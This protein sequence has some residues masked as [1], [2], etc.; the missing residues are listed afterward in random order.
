[1]SN[2]TALIP[3]P[4]V[5]YVSPNA[6]G[7]LSYTP[8]T[9]KSG[10]AI[11]TVTVDDG[12]ATT[13]QTFTVT[14]TPM[15]DTPSI[16]SAATMVN[17]QTTSGLVVSRNPAD[18]VEVTHVK[19]TAISGG[20]LFLNDGTTPIPA[21][22]FITIAQGAA[23]LQFTPAT[24]P[25][26]TGHVSIQASTSNVDAGL[27]AGIVTADI[28]VT[29]QTSATTVTTSGSPS[30]LADLVTFTATVTP[31]I[32]ASSGTVQFKDGGT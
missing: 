32:A 5:T 31:A 16:T 3:N 23:G 24:S 13:V 10:T 2:N 1:W 7:S 8:V 6:T 22:A 25:L 9:D 20:T 21:G 27:G 15:A 4:A 30:I 18:G 26:A 12:L 14:V 17:T 19:I 29:S 28:V 11:I